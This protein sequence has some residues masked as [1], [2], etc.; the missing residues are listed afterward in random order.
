MEKMNKKILITAFEPF[1]DCR[2]NIT[3]KILKDL[4][5]GRGIYKSLL[6]LRSFLVFFLMVLS[7]SI[8]CLNLVVSIPPQKYFVEK[9]ADENSDISV[10]IGPGVDAHSFSPTPSQLMRLAKADIYFSI[11]LEFEETLLNKVININN[12]IRIVPLDSVCKK[13][14]MEDPFD[15]HDHHE[16][17]GHSHGRYDP[18]VWT[19]IENVKKM[20]ERITEVLSEHE[21]EKRNIYRKRKES[22]FSELDEL[23]ETIKNNLSIRKENRF[24][25]IFHP[26]WGYFAQEFDLVQIPVEIEG[27]EPTISELRHLMD[28][29]EEKNVRTLFVQPQYGSKAPD[30]IA[31]HI[32]AELQEIYALEYDYIDNMRLFSEKLR[33]SFEEEE[34]NFE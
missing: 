30:I 22:F 11:G 18:H 8:S 19:S 23:K 1:R 2:E 9:I 13:R 20:T 21:E 16:H 12:S 28:F 32:G 17:S 3:E 15:S 33:R 29:A 14:E 4:K 31:D 27:K 34:A 26:S 24:F 25:M 5:N 10:M 7:L 6:P